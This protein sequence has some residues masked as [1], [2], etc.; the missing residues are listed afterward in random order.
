M[1]WMGCSL[2]T[3]SLLA[4]DSATE[5][6][7]FNLVSIAPYISE[8]VEYIPAAA[9]SNLE[10]KLGE[11]VAANGVGASLYNTRFVITPNVTVMSKNITATA[12]PR[13]AVNLY[14]NLYVGD[15]FD[16]T[17]FGSASLNLKGVGSNE[18]KAYISAFN[19]IKSG[20]PEIRRLLSTAKQRI[21]DYYNS[22]CDL[23]IREAELA[24]NTNELDRAMAMLGAVPK[25]N[26]DCYEKATEMIVPVY[27]KKINRDCAIQLSAARNAWNAG[28]DHNAA[29]L[30]ME[31]LKRIEPEA[32]CFGEA[33]RLSREIGNR[34]E[35]IDD[36]D[37]D[38]I[39]KV[40]QD[41][42]D[43]QRSAIDAAREVGVAHGNNQPQNV[44]YNVK[45][46]W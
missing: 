38:F 11:I 14:V 32:E 30:A 25:I 7:E 34:V 2:T 36:R 3:A 41:E 13:V 15:G 5:F 20:N 19:Q 29:L 39:L 31:R 46:W 16:G 28:Q 37:W 35:E 23:I 6:D 21:V 9:K 27:R 12:P 10:N 42:V 4:Q 44:S 40:Q 43:L 26:M 22:N 18:N 45:G 24:A 8:Q 1:M 33:Q 17:K